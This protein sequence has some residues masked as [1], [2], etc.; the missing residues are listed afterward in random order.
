MSL[1]LESE[2]VAKINLKL[3][4]D[5]E[6]VHVECTEIL[7]MLQASHSVPKT[8]HKDSKNVYKNETLV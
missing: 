6:I 5:C 8:L 3:N 7:L 2:I 1:A 4:K